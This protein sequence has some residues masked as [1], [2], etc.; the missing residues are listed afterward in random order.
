MRSSVQAPG[1]VSEQKKT[2]S[3]A[4]HKMEEGSHPFAKE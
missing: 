2:P 4:T 3:A 1:T